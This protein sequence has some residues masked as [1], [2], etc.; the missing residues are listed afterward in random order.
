MPESTTATR[1]RRRPIRS[2]VPAEQPR[3]VSKAIL[4]TGIDPA[5]AQ[6]IQRLRDYVRTK[7]YRLFG[8]LTTMQVLRETGR[9]TIDFRRD[10]MTV[11]I[12]ADKDDQLLLVTPWSG[13]P[14]K[15][16]DSQEFCPVC[17]AACDVC[18]G[19][20]TEACPKETSLPDQ[21]C[22]EEGC[23]GKTGKYNSKCKPC[24]GT[25]IIKASAKCATCKGTGIT[26]CSACRG[27]GSYP[28]CVIAGD[29]SRQDRFRQNCPKCKGSGRAHKEIPVD[30]HQ[31]VN[32]QQ[33]TM[34]FIGP[35]V[36]F[37]IEPVN[38]GAGIVPQVF[39]VVPDQSGNLMVMGIEQEA[40]GC[41]AYLIGGVWK[42]ALKV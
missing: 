41:G 26:K 35:I 18:K 31:F 12:A 33:G 8:T 3:A 36:R 42:P 20:K 39:D 34:L 10:G 27:T 29:H 19:S 38:Q 15:W 22:Q 32:A 16:D 4:A 1:R 6:F 14:P 23:T 5:L 28:T 25:G 11:A 13:I 7:N 21:V 24:G 17:L 37:V 30:L 9:H 2:E 40:P